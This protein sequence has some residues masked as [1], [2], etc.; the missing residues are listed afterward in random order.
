MQGR[1]R[2][3]CG[4]RETLVCETQQQETMQGVGLGGREVRYVH[5]C[6]TLTCPYEIDAIAPAVY[7]PTPGS[8]FCRSSAVLGIRPASSDTTWQR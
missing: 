4:L 3:K 6:P 1:A 8:N 7:R 5:C 2:A